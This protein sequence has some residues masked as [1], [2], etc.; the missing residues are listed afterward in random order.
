MNELIVLLAA[1]CVFWLLVWGIGH[2][3]EPQPVQ[4]SQPWPLKAVLY[5]LLAVAAVWWLV[6]RYGL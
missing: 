2:I 5:V 1:V 4:G 3:P 6:T